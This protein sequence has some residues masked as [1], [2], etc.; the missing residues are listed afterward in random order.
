MGLN[1][2]FLGF[3]LCLYFFFFPSLGLGLEFFFLFGLSLNLLLFFAISPR[4]KFFAFGRGLSLD[5]LFFCFRLGLCLLV[6][7]QL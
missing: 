5:F 7:L 6:F 4:L 3:R 2:L 1:F